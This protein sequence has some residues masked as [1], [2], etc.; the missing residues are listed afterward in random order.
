MKAAATMTKRRREFCLS[1]LIKSGAMIS[2]GAQPGI[3]TQGLQ[4]RMDCYQTLAIAIVHDPFCSLMQSNQ[5]EYT[6]VLSS[7]DV[8]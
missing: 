7:V 2:C 5:A 4:T 6:N 8:C 3:G 1:Q